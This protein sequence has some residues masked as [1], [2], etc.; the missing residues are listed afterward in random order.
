MWYFIYELQT[1]TV[2]KGYI[3]RIETLL[4]QIRRLLEGIRWMDRMS[5]KRCFNKL[6]RQNTS[7]QLHWRCPAGEWSTIF[8]LRGNSKREKRRGRK[9]LK[10]A[11]DAQCGGCRTKTSLDGDSGGVW[12]VK[13]H[14][15]DDKTLRTICKQTSLALMFTR[16]TI[17]L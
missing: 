10:R 11:V 12:S 8:C 7:E 2:R 14:T 4:L 13:H 6:R 17:L 1:W 15:Q 16:L 3:Q 5:N 9:I